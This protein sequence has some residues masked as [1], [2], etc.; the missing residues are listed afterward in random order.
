MEEIDSFASPDV[1]RL[2][3]GN[4]CDL[5]GKREVDH[6]RAKVREKALEFILTSDL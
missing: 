2:L 6:A 3:V 5:S 1:K 4:K